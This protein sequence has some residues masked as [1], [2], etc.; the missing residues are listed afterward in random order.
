MSSGILAYDQLQPPFLCFMAHY[1]F[2]IIPNKIYA[3][4]NRRFR[5]RPG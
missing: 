1:S 4:H 5:S 2:C 3:F